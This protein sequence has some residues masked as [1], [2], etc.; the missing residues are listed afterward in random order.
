MTSNASMSPLLLLNKNGIL[1]QRYS[2]GVVFVV[3]VVF[4]KAAM[5]NFATL[6]RKNLRGNLFE[7]ETSQL[8]GF[9]NMRKG[10]QPCYKKDSIA[11]VFL[12]ML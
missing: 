11:R 7:V 2:S 5:K 8:S 1:F 4:R 10:L 6:L 3:G 12:G 9:Y